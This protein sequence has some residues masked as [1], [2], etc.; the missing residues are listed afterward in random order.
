VDLLCGVRF[1]PEPA[2]HLSLLP[3]L[4]RAVVRLLLTNQFQ[5][6]W[7]AR[8]IQKSILAQQE[9]LRRVETELLLAQYGAWGP[10]VL[11]VEKKIFI[12]LSCLFFII[13]VY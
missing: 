4:R 12:I 9:E 2:L 10:T 11:K 8:E 13:F 1:P 7:K 6:E 3:I 5:L